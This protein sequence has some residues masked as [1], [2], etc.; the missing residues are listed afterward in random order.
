MVESKNRKVGYA[1]RISPDTALT[2]PLTGNT[3]HRPNHSLKRASSRPESQAVTKGDES[4]GLGTILFWQ[5]ETRH[6]GQKLQT[7]GQAIK[8]AQIEKTIVGVW[9]VSWGRL[10][11]DAEL[12][13][14]PKLGM[15]PGDVG[16][17][18]HPLLAEY[19]RTLPDE[20]EEESPLFALADALVSLGNE[21]NATELP[22]QF[23]PFRPHVEVVAPAVQ[24]A[25][26][27][28]AGKLW[29]EMARHLRRVANYEEARAAIERALAINEAAFGPDHPNVATVVNNLG[30]VLGDLGDHEGARAA[31]ERALAIDKEVCGLNHPKVARNFNN[32]GSVLSDLGDHAGAWAAYER[33]LAIF[34]GFLPPEH[35][36]ITGVRG[37]LEALSE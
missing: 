3:W 31:Y 21:A 16:P 36:Y 10:A 24:E 5:E 9:Q 20:R 17:A 7:V 35:P 8:E 28:Q 15:E 37:N 32:L 6:L 11:A 26:L 2:N 29:G 34:E 13:T 19:A 33:A 25:E 4:V 27:A 12:A 14:A 18:I 30:S 22:T 23:I 1:W